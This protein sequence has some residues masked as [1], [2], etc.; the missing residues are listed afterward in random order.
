MTRI[1]I[2]P[3]LRG[4]EDKDTILIPHRASVAFWQAVSHLHTAQYIYINMEGL[5]IYPVT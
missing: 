2:S 4:Q 1:S 3:L 5:G